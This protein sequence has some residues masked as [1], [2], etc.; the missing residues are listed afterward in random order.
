[1]TK[2]DF[3]KMVARERIDIKGG[4]SKVGLHTLESMGYYLTI[5]DE[6]SDQLMAVTEAELMEL[7]AILNKKYGD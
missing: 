3:K 4:E 1:M 5:I 7:Y 6:H 2:E